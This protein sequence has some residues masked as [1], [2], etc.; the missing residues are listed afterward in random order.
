MKEREQQAK[1]EPGAAN[2]RFAEAFDQNYDL[3]F[4]YLR[5]RL[6]AELAADLTAET[7]STA[8]REFDRFDPDR[9]SVR[10]WLFGIAANTMRHEARREKRELKAY[11]RTG[12]DPVVADPMAET[13]RRLDAESRQRDLARGLSSLGTDDREA[14]LL[15]SWGEL[16]YPEISEALGV[17]IGTVKSRIARARKRLRACLGEDETARKRISEETANG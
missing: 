13:D 15:L 1:R 4:R 6:P 14:L 11:A 16:S 8:L 17:P 3:I 9:G 2:A 7:F 12:V 5:R 10:A